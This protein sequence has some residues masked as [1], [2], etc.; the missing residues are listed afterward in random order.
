MRSVVL[1]L[2]ETYEATAG[3]VV[4]AR[5]RIAQVAAGAGATA[6]QVDAVRLAASEALTNAVVHAY[7]DEPG[8]IH[9]NAA[10]VASELWILISDDGC[11]LQPRADRPGLGLGLGLISQVSDDFAI[12]SRASGGTEVRIRFNLAD[13]THESPA[14]EPATYPGSR[15]DVRPAGFSRSM[16]TA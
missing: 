6:S 7:R 15:R 5:T 10:V 8:G 9:V 11:G 13:G 14:V 16:S 12:V 4:E 3:S 2:N 1:N